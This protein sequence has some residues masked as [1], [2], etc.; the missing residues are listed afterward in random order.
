MSKGQKTQIK[1][2]KWNQSGIYNIFEPFYN[3]LG[4]LLS[5]FLLLLFLYHTIKGSK[6]GVLLVW[7]IVIKQSTENTVIC[8]QIT[9][10]FLRVQTKH[11][12]LSVSSFISALERVR[13]TFLLFATPTFTPALL[14]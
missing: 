11:S 4:N 2:H 9:Q 13:R 10:L 12:D 14:C 5:M 7:S 6:W 8:V 3:V 1:L